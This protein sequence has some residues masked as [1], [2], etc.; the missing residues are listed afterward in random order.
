MALLPL[1]A[2]QTGLA[3]AA[4]SAWLQPEFQAI[5]AEAVA[6]QAA[7]RPKVADMAEASLGQG[8]ECIPAK[9]VVSVFSPQC[10]GVLRRST[11]HRPPDYH[12]PNT[13]KSGCST[14][15]PWV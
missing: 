6:R 12:L 4:Q 8:E 10:L 7:P 2:A 15:K 13:S 11:N 14:L 3:A 9:I 5:Y 1:T